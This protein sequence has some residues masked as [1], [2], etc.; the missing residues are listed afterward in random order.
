M[1]FKSNFKTISTVLIS[2]FLMHQGFSQDY[3]ILFFDKVKNQSIVNK[4]GKSPYVYELVR[5]K[6]I[7]PEKDKYAK[8]LTTFYKKAISYKNQ[9]EADSIKIAEFKQASQ[10]IIG[11]DENEVNYRLK[12][13]RR[14]LKRVK[15]YEYV[16]V[17]E[18][19]FYY[20]LKISRSIFKPENV[21]VGKFKVL[22]LFYVAKGVNGLTESNLISVEEAKDNNL[23]K[24]DFLFNSQFYV[25]QNLENN[26]YFMVATDFI[27]K[28][29]V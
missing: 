14:T 12:V 24:D 29:P 19:D 18:D 15:K 9:A 2:F 20:K 23:T 25:I 17:I 21:I 1:I 22:G 16:K 7:I 27:K 26:L 5:E 28:F 10:P 4:E 11:L 3:D 13:C 8:R 6:F